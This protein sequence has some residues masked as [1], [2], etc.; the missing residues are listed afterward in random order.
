MIRMMLAATA[1]AVLTTAGPA[2]AATSR[3][4]RT[5]LTL[6]YMAD[7]G[8]AAAVVLSC[9]PVGGVH[10]KGR[11]ACALLKKVGGRPDRLRAAATAMCTLEY[12]P[13]TA[14]ISGT[15][16]GRA[17]DWSQK[18]SNR[19]DLARTTGVLFAF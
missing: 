12:A 16:K 3:P 15:W 1:V 18:F 17:V 11:K 10:P 9:N 19:C 2:A 5:D 8:Y 7:A 13:I 4:A 14:E 6:T